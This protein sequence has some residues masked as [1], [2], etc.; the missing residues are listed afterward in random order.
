MARLK[1][2]RVTLNSLLRRSGV[3]S[4]TGNVLD[5]TANQKRVRQDDEFLQTI[6]TL[7]TRTGPVSEALTAAAREFKGG[8]GLQEV[9]GDF[10]DAI[11]V[12]IAQTGPD[13]VSVGTPGRRPGQPDRRSD[14][15]PQARD[16]EAPGAVGRPT[17][18]QPDQG[19]QTVLPGAG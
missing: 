15:A 10:I 3:I 9:T 5:E 7:A 6:N 14:Q 12:A 16:R 2:D 18:D 1:K 4:A 8:R 19:L 17:V 13:R 11:K